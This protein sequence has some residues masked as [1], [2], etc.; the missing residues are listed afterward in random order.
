MNLG[1]KK[2]AV[3]LGG[4]NDAQGGSKGPTD[5]PARF[6]TVH[7]HIIHPNMGPNNYCGGYKWIWGWGRRRED[8]E[9]EKERE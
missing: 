6:L 1:F 4:I 7:N 8:R 5:I 3:K 2:V 9:G